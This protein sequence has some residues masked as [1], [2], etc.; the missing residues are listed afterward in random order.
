MLIYEIMTTRVVTVEMDDSIETIRKIFNNVEFHHILVVFGKKLMG[1]ISD[2]DCLQAVSP[3]LD[4]FSEEKRDLNALRKKAHQIMSRKPITIAKNVT[5]ETAAKLLMKHNIG[6]LPVMDEDK[7]VIGI[8][9]WK[10]LLLH[11]T[12]Y[13]SLKKTTAKT[14]RTQKNK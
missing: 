10:D 3:F 11:Y 9:S 7:T 5:I 4:T 13:A 6:C 12:Q 8:V 1:V 2:R 14:K